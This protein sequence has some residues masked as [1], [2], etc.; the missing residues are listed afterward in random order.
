M[1]VGDVVKVKKEKCFDVFNFFIE[2]DNLGVVRRVVKNVITIDFF[3]GIKHGHDGS[4]DKSIVPDNTCYNLYETD[5]ELVNMLTEYKGFHV[6]DRI[7]TITDDFVRDKKTRGTIV[8]FNKNSAYPILIKYDK[9]YMIKSGHSHG[10]LLDWSSNQGSVE[11]P[12]YIKVIYPILGKTK[13]DP[14]PEPE[15]NKYTDFEL[16]CIEKIRR[17]F[18]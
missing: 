16:K 14:E 17:L 15:V 18:L 10:G 9:N 5:L 4:F 2:K 8:G 6:G 7:E 13:Q 12:E 11:R 3:K 1:K